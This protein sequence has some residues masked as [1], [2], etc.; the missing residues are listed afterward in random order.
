MVKPVMSGT[1]MTRTCKSKAEPLNISNLKSMQFSPVITG[2]LSL[3]QIFLDI[4]G[5]PDTAGLTIYFNTHNPILEI[6]EIFH[7]YSSQQVCISSYYCWISAIEHS[8]T[9]SIRL[10]DLS[11]KSFSVL[12]IHKKNVKR[13]LNSPPN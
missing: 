9:N 7:Q 5:L 3:G 6:G 11:S 1:C 13:L 2:H 8:E 10:G 4:Q 12:T